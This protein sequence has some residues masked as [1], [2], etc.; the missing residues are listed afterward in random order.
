MA[1]SYG[2]VPNPQDLIA[3]KIRPHLVSPQGPSPV[4]IPRLPLASATVASSFLS[5]LQAHAETASPT[6]GSERRSASMQGQ[7]SA[8]TRDSGVATPVA[9]DQTSAEELTKAL[10]A[11]RVISAKDPQ[12]EEAQQDGDQQNQ[13]STRLQ[14]TQEQTNEARCQA[15]SES[16]SG[17]TVE[18]LAPSDRSAILAGIARLEGV[19]VAAPKEKPQPGASASVLQL[20]AASVESASP[21]ATS[22]SAEE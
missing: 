6:Q 22:I 10:E 21:E 5:Q 19:E 1:P 2:F 15:E 17:D 7:G 16:F 3:Q 11:P 4:P 8:Q 18:A 13:M 9:T 12:S 20:E 14:D